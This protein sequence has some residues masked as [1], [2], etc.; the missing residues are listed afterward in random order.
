MAH[1]QDHIS[2]AASHVAAK[3]AALDG[4][5]PRTGASGLGSGRIIEV[6]GHPHMTL[7][8]T[9]VGAVTAATVLLEGSNDKTN[10]KTLATNAH[11]GD[12]SK[13]AEVD[14]K[15]Y[16]FARV[17]KSVDAGAADTI[18]YFLRLAGASGPF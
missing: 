14:T 12:D 15:A 5:F 9:Q 7:Q 13:F 17:R 2:A 6:L 4:T 11:A 8:T 16:R 1:A 18:D 10:W 3:G